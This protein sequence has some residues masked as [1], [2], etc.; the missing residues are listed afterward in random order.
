MAID[1]RTRRCAG[2]CLNITILPFHQF[3][4]P[5]MA[6]NYIS[7]VCEEYNLLVTIVENY[8]FV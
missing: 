5:P 8:R 6:L 7:V 1:T 3:S 2:R 4:V